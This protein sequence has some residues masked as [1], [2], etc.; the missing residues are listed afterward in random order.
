MGN[1]RVLLAEDHTLVREGTR[2]MLERDPNILVVGEAE[3]GLLA[4][5]MARD[6]APDVVLLDVN[7]PLLNGIEA[8]HRIR[9]EPNAP[10]ILMLSAYDDVDYARAA[11]QAGAGGYMLKTAHARDV[12]AAVVSV[13]HGEIVL[14]PSVARQLLDGRG[15]GT[16]GHALSNREQ[17]VLRLAA[18]GERT[19]EIARQLSVSVRTI[20]AQ[21]TSI[22][23]K[24]GVS[25][26]TEAVIY[27]ASHGWVSLDRPGPGSS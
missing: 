15:Q 8:A 16:G 10:R 24:L 27:A 21:F 20:E 12:I 14:H 3:D 1:V 22:F 13:A 25:S 6:L 11:L 19:K 18:K 17:D 7:L 9:S 2:E 26:R 5:T 23:N 4:V